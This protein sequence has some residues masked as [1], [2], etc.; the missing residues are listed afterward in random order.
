MRHKTIESLLTSSV[1][2]FRG[3]AVKCI[4]WCF[5]CIKYIQNPREEERILEIA[6][7]I[8]A[9]ENV[10]TAFEKLVVHH[11]SLIDSEVSD[12]ED[13]SW[14]VKVACD[15]EL[16]LN[17]LHPFISNGTISFHF[18]SPATGQDSLL[19]RKR[20]CLATTLVVLNA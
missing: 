13:E 15:L 16:L 10:A 6:K 4:L 2:S 1:W 18:N 3:F 19:L 8:F 14:L 17:T 11:V 12:Q 5:N 7:N 9:P 20:E